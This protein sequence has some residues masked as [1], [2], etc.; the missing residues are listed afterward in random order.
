MLVLWR[1]TRISYKHG[2]EK[3][4]DAKTWAAGVHRRGLQEMCLGGESPEVFFF[5]KKSAYIEPYRV[6]QEEEDMNSV[7]ING[8]PVVE[9]TDELCERLCRWLTQNTD[10]V[11]SFG[12]IEVPLVKAKKKA[13]KKAA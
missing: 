11:V 3:I 2:G 4:D 13:K 7:T 1:G 9:I 8:H 10:A 12:D 6:L 5:K